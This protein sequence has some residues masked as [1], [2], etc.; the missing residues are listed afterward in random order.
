[1]TEI[2]SKEFKIIVLGDSEVGKTAILNRLTGD[3]FDEEELEPTEGMSH[4]IYT[5]EIPDLGNFTFRIIDTSGDETYLNEVGTKEFSNVS[6]AI[7]V[8]DCGNMKSLKEIK[9]WLNLI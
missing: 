1:M 5:G 4:M 2:K 3:V 7:L 6:A 8:Y 9:N